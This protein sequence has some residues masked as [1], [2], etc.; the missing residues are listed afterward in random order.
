MTH[1]VDQGIV[2]SHWAHGNVCGEIEGGY[3]LMHKERAPAMVIIGIPR[4]GIGM[5]DRAEK[6][7]GAA[8]DTCQ[9]M[10]ARQG[11][12]NEILGL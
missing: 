1:E 10:S 12:V 6:V 3:G 8:G 5:P 4:G 9:F 2:C 11:N 7:L